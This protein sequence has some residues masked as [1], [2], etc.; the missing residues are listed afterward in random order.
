M[1][2]LRIGVGRLV[3]IIR[4]AIN[5]FC[6]HHILRVGIVVFLGVRVRDFGLALLF[7]LRRV[8]SLVGLLIFILG[9][10]V[11]RVF[12]LIGVGQVFAQI[13]ILDEVT[14]RAAKVLLVIEQLF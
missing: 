8:R 12:I 13:K 11:F 2:A 4:L 7:F 6:V 1:R 10:F 14:D 5:I 9:G 3:A